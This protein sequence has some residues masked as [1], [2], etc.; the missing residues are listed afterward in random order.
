MA[1]T[2]KVVNGDVVVSSATGRPTL[3]SG[4]PKLSQDIYEFFTVDVQPNGFGAGLEQLI[5]IVEVSPDMFMSM[6][7]RQIREGFVRFLGLINNNPKIGRTP[8]EQIANITNITFSVDNTDP[9]RFYFNANIVTRN[10]VNIPVDTV[11][12][13]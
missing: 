11:F 13:A 2:L 7:D 8:S 4:S 1:Q 3:I 5:G 6:G 10:G 12:E 9:T